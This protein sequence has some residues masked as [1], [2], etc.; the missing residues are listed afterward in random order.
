[1]RVSVD[2]FEPGRVFSGTLRTYESGSQHSYPATLRFDSDGPVQF[3]VSTEAGRGLFG[4]DSAHESLW[5]RGDQ[6]LPDQCLFQSLDGQFTLAKI[7]SVRRSRNG[8][9][10]SAQFVADEVV[11]RGTQTSIHVP[12]GFDE[13]SSVV[14]GLGEWW[15]QRSLLLTSHHF[16]NGLV[17]RVDITTDESIQPLQWTQNGATMRIEKGWRTDAPE[18]RSAWSLIELTHLVSRFPEPSSAD[19]HLDE[20]WKVRSLVA[21]M[22]GAPSRYREHSIAS[23]SFSERL[24]RSNDTVEYFTPKRPFVTRRTVRDFELPSGPFSR[25]GAILWLRDIGELGLQAWAD[26]WDEAWERL[27]APTVAV[28]SR[29]EPFV[30]DVILATGIF[31]DAWGKRQ[32]K[33][34]GERETYSTPGPGKKP[35]PTF[36]TYAFRALAKS[37]A[38]WSNA[39]TSNAGLARAIRDV[40]TAVK[41]AEKQQPDA[42][43]LSLLS[44]VSLLLVRLVAAHRI[45]DSGDLVEQFTSS[46]SF[47]KELSGFIE[48]GVIIG[49]DGTFGP[50]PL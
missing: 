37:G 13:L 22:F 40:Y 43:V 18:D 26:S 3:E 35:T 12:M 45:D 10:S 50:R 20:H 6:F 9:V 4:E 19:R 47:E 38:A 31:I 29:P 46:W 17:E 28:L 8:F 41:H 33:V 15:N 42:L 34:D 44:T 39:A 25:S 48:H 1:M 49:D 23:S 27:I 2:A 5:F 24:P 21:L 11:L 14:S 32:S 16:D 30:D 36:A 7:R